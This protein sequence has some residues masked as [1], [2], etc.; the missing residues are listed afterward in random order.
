MSIDILKFNKLEKRVEELEKK[1]DLL[2]NSNL[3]GNDNICVL[4]TNIDDVS[5]EILGY[6]MEKLSEVALDVSFYP[7]FMKKNRPAYCLRV[8]T[9]VEKQAEISDLIMKLTGTLGV[10]VFEIT[11]HIGQREIERVNFDV[12]NNIVHLKKSKY[13]EKLE[14]DDLR[15]LLEVNDIPI[16]KIID[17]IKYEYYQNKEI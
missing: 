13:R 5:G 10:R 15:R 7:I 16:H 6:A 8:I 14:F 3:V 9:K 4:E 12:L 11:R 2:N 1:L 17:M